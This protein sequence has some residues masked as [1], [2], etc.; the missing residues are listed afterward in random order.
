MNR[1]FCTAF[2]LYLVTLKYNNST[3]IEV[4]EHF[5]LQEAGYIDWE[6]STV[7]G[8]Q[9]PRRENEG[10]MSMQHDL[11]LEQMVLFPTRGQNTLHITSYD[12]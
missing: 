2:Q 11:A 6:S 9:L 8:H 7:K 5:I 1:I 4:Y 3:G 10:L 12:H